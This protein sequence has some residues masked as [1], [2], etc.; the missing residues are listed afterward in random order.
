MVN[1]GL[2]VRHQGDIVFVDSETQRFGLMVLEIN[3]RKVSVENLTNFTNETANKANGVGT[4]LIECAVIRALEKRLPLVS[5]FSVKT[6]LFFYWKLGFRPIDKFRCLQMGLEYHLCAGQTQMLKSASENYESMPMTLPKSGFALWKKKILRDNNPLLTLKAF[7]AIL[8][9][10][11]NWADS[12]FAELIF[13]YFTGTVK[14]PNTSLD[15][16]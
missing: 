14:A 4:I 2:V 9:K 6:A 10:Q 7:T 5:L 1:Q 13:A 15:A 3:Y 16:L 12:K 8:E 11:L